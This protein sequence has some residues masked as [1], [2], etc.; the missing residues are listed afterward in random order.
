MRETSVLLAPEILDRLRRELADAR[1]AYVFGSIL[2]AAFGEESDVDVAVDLGEPLTPAR[3]Y[4]L[5]ADLV[6]ATGRE[7]DV[8]DLR[9]ADP[10]IKMQV[11]RYGRL[12]LANDQRACYSFAMHTLSEYVDLKIDRAPVEAMIARSRAV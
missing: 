6:A 5:A 3:R 12:L 2:T 4:E 9:T 10:I 11:L 7:V 8:I 1:F